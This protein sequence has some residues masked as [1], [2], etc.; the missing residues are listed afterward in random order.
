MPLD[1]DPDLQGLR[2]ITVL[3]DGR[4]YEGDTAEMLSD[5]I[6]ARNRYVIRESPGDIH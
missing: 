6:F 5:N 3:L 1:H 4:W 2:A